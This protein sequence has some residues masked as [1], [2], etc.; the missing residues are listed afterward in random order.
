MSDHVFPSLLPAAAAIATRG[1]IVAAVAATALFLACL[2]GHDFLLDGGWLTAFP[3][4][5][6]AVVSV[7]LG[8]FLLLGRCHQSWRHLGLADITGLVWA[9]TLS[10]LAL[11][12]FDTAATTAGAGNVGLRLPA[13][14][15]VG[16]W[17]WTIILLAGVRGFWW[18]FHE[19]LLAAVPAVRLRP[20]ET[21]ALLHRD[22]V[23]LDTA[24]VGGLIG[25]RTVLVTGAGGSIGSELCRHV[26][27]FQPARLVLIDR[28]ENT[29]FL[30]A[31]DL[32]RRVPGAIIE[33]LI[34]DITDAGRMESIMAHLRPDVVFHAAAHKH[35]S[36]M[37]RDPAEAI[38]NN[39]LGTALLARLASRYRAE[40]FV[41][42]ST[43]KAVNPTSVMGCSKLIAERCV[44]A[45]AGR[46]HTRFMVVRFGNVLASNGSVVP[47]F[48]EQIRRGGPITVT[49]PDIARYFMTIPE[50]SQLVLQAASMGCGGEVFVLDMGQRV[51]I[52]DLARSLIRL[53]GLD[54][55][56]IAIVYT[57]LTPG[58]RLVEQLYFPDER[59]CR[60][61]HPKVFSAVHR[62]VDA[63]ETAALL[64][65]LVAMV[66]EPAEK[67][68]ARL[69]ELVPEFCADDRSSKQVACPHG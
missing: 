26:L 49:H 22:P 20:V 16:D 31:H 1:V 36:M 39:C 12:A 64:D 7:K 18:S 52:V 23:A 60:T 50:A 8:V 37:E 62:P 9:A 38:K 61:A 46:S 51:R 29:L 67:V 47:I 32:L 24:A 15:V 44:Q 68:R 35:V 54:P 10:M 69:R 30:T 45:L 66:D 55:D 63:A 53:S 4:T 5:A 25:G 40:A 3:A 57:G 65:S 58:E 21:T 42:I 56:E 11:A 27:E 33:P 17:A 59:P 2:A 34:A 43:D 13:S 41:L 28:G 19:E 48:L 6:A 14:V